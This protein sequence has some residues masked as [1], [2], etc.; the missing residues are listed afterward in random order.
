[1]LSIEERIAALQK[2]LAQEREKKARLLARRKAAEAKKSRATDTR[3]KILIGAAVLSKVES[4][5]MPRE[6]LLSL[7]DS[8]LTRPADRALFDLPPLAADHAT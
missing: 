4:G 1:M 2:K 7:L 5:A 8:A 3:K 6:R